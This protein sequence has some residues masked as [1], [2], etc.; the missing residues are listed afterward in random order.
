MPHPRRAAVVGAA[1]V[2]LDATGA[3]AQS[4]PPD[5]DQ[6]FDEARALMAQSRFAE[7]CAKLESSEAQDPGIGTEFNLARCYELAGRPASARA[8]YRRVVQ[9]THVAG[10]KERETVARDLEKQLEPRVAHLALHVRAP[11]PALEIRVDGALVPSSE[12]S[13]PLEVDPGTHAVEASETAFLSWKTAVKVVKDGEAVPVDVPPLLPKAALEPVAPAPPTTP[14]PGAA[15]TAPRTSSQRVVAMALGAVG[16]VGLVPGSY[17]GLR[18][19]SLE[20]QASP[21]CPANACDGTG[22]SLRTSSRWNGDASTVTFALSGA[23]LAAAGIVWLTA[24]R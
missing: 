24:P 18:A 14:A 5:P 12:W 17:F 11:T 21:H 8:M 23:V 2:L 9:E 16:L 3:L 1:L 13:A 7:A 19:V 20:S 4:A 15:E 22:Y 6:L 10:E